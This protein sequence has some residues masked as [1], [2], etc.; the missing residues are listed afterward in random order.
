MDGANK[1]FSLMPDQKACADIQALGRVARITQSRPVYAYRY[2][3]L[4]TPDQDNIRIQMEKLVTTGALTGDFDGFKKTNMQLST[5]DRQAI[6]KLH[7]ARKAPFFAKLRERTHNLTAQGAS[8]SKQT[9][10][11]RKRSR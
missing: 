1:V 10:G 6:A 9:D 11:K 7:S 3:V 8:A 2:I 4:G 5:N